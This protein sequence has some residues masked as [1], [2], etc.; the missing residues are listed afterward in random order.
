MCDEMTFQPYLNTGKWNQIAHEGKEAKIQESHH[1]V[2]VNIIYGSTKAD[3]KLRKKDRIQL[4][5][6]EIRIDTPHAHRNAGKD[7]ERNEEGEKDVPALN[8]ILQ[9]GQDGSWKETKV[10]FQKT[11][12]PVSERTTA[13]RSVRRIHQQ[14]HSSQR[15]EQGTWPCNS[16]KIA[17]AT[18]KN[19]PPNLHNP[20]DFLETS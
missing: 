10:Q 11:N 2:E 14:M 12:K 17:E 16:G 13:Q 5:T 15:P 4:L 6:K 7:R 18:R 1:S 9:K 3:A 19:N 20:S 8:V